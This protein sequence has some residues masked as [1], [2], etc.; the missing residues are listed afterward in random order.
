MRNT[1]ID[2]NSFKGYMT[3][4]LSELKEQAEIIEKIDCRQREIQQNLEAIKIELSH[5]VD[6][7]ELEQLKSA[8]NVHIAENGAYRNAKSKISSDIKW[9]M[10][11]VVSFTI[12]ILSII[13]DVIF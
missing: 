10:G 6:K 11:F 2:N 5:K 8:L 12:S 9:K 3:T 1:E 13:K 4:I 7:I